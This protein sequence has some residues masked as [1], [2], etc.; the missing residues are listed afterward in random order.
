[1]AKIEVLGSFDRPDPPEFS[2]AV[3][4]THEAP[5]SGGVGAVLARGNHREWL[6][7]QDAAIMVATPDKFERIA[8]FYGVTVYA[9]KHRRR[10]LEAE[11]AHEMRGA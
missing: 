2:G 6:P 4:D 3:R 1:M 8:K 10:M 5:V 11:I 9:L 7:H